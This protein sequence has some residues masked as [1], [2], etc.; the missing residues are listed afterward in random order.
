MKQSNINI[1]AVP[2]GVE[3]E[4]GIKNLF[5]EMITENFIDLRGR[6]NHKSTESQRRG[7]QEEKTHCN[8]NGKG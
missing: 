8:Y 7:T 2:E 5:E 1:T 6:K 4:E 3:V